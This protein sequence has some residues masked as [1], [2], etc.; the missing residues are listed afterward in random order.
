MN[1][2][3]V[4][5]RLRQLVKTAGRTPNA[6]SELAGLDRTYL[7]L[8]LKGSRAAFGAAPM[9]ALAQLFGVDIGWLLLGTGPMPNPDAI[10]ASV[11]QAESASKAQGH[12]SVQPRQKKAADALPCALD[13]ADTEVP[14]GD[15]AA[16]LL[17]DRRDAAVAR[18]ILAT[19]NDAADHAATGTGD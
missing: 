19:A 17:A 8:V 5:K 7:R 3:D 15:P 13:P 9:V 11:T 4:A 14:A 6:L 12:R 18:S 10:R 16:A 1:P 2:R